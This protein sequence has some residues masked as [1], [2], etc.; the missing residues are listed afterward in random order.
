MN[1]QEDTPDNVLQDL[2]FSSNVLDQNS[3]AM[4]MFDQVQFILDRN[5]LLTK[6]L[7]RAPRHQ[8]VIASLPNSGTMS[9][10]WHDPTV[11]RKLRVISD[12]DQRVGDLV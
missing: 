1:A 7:G 10:Q 4:G 5:T 6:S 2:A 12:M 3:I 8:E 11:Y 9:Y